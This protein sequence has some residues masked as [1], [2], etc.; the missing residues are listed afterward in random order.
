VNCNDIIQELYNNE[1]INELIIKIKPTE[2]QDDLR[3]EFAISLL[4]YNCD[5]L[6]KIRNEGNLLGFALRVLWTIGTSK[7][8]KFYNKFKKNDYEKAIKYFDSQKGKSISIE[9]VTL[10][11]NI[12]KNKL[13][14]SPMDAHESI[15]FNKYV[16]LRSCND[17]ANYFEIPSSHVFAVVKKMKQELKKAING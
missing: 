11:E 17:V 9:K 4:E 14:G 5:K 10:V 1:K 7:R 6:I 13:K 15:I 8:S 3:Q 12:L 2:L 16:E